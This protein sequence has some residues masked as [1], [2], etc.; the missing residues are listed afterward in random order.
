MT[1]GVQKFEPPES[2]L[3]QGDI[4]KQSIV[5]P[6]GDYEVRILRTVDGKHGSCVFETGERFKIFDI[7]DLRSVLS[8][9]DK[10]PL[11]T[12]PFQVTSDGQKE[13]VVVY[14]NLFEYFIV[15]SQTCDISGV[16]STPKPFCAIVP[17]KTL[18]SFCRDEIVPVKKDGD[19]IFSGTIIDMI[20][21]FAQEDL[22]DSNE[23]EFP[24]KLRD[25]IG[26]WKPTKNTKEHTVKSQ[27]KGF[28]NNLVGNQKL[29]IYYIEHSPEF[30][31]PEGFADFTQIITVP[32]NM[33]ENT[34]EKRIAKL[35]NSYNYDFAQRLGRFLTRIATP[36]PMKGQKF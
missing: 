35:E 10:N 22:S 9:Q 27:I 8:H 33:L 36:E 7:E 12:Q 16:D 28:L 6:F 25:F 17:F 31:V 4:F 3:S 1:D 30:N 15:A 20:S 5:A 11:R 34:K 32:T 18:L 24:N 19:T 14:G 13:L 2:F 29:A 26:K 21:K 23:F